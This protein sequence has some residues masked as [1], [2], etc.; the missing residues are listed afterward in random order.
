MAKF[1]SPRYP[2]GREGGPL[3][4]P[5]SAHAVAGNG[6]PLNWPP[7]AHAV[8]GNGGP[9]NW[10][11]SAHAVAGDGG[12]LNWPPAAHAVAGNGGPLSW[13]PSADAV[14]GN[15]PKLVSRSSMRGED[16]SSK[17]SVRVPPA[18]V[19]KTSLTLPPW[20]ANRWTGKLSSNSL[21]RIQPTTFRNARRPSVFTRWTP[22]SASRLL[23]EGAALS[24]GPSAA[25]VAGDIPS[26]VP[27][28]QTRVWV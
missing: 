4:W 11:P 13:R 26:P 1:T 8:A 3:N 23:G 20:I 16:G 19:T 28:S 17:T 7:S 21:H 15:K 12:P 18:K 27:L 14:A 24:C 5:P 9:L 25:A 6:G 10:P 2:S 22:K